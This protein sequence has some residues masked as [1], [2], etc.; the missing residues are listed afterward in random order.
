MN[1]LKKIVLIALLIPVA[2][3][4][5]SLF[6]SSRYRVERSVTMR[7]KPSAIFSQINTLKQWPEWTAWTVAKYPDM[8]VYFT[9]PEAGG[10]AVC[11][12]EG[13][14]SGQG[15]LKLTRSDP[16][17][18][19]GYDLDFERGK[20]P[21]KGVITI[22]PAGDSV[23]VSWSNEGDLGWNPVSR[24]FGLFMDKMMG[25]DFEEGLLNLREKVETKP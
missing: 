6:L 11:S 4:V 14:S 20:Y 19:I 10:G 3:V 7:A 24:F 23:K 8:K 13:Q 21:S 1:A 17:K 16:D 18:S 25:P 9:G 12:W 15:T 5:V 22:E 2:L